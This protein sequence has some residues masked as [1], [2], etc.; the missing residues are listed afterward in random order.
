MIRPPLRD[1]LAICAALLLLLPGTA[2]LSAQGPGLRATPIQ[3]GA[4][5]AL[6]PTAETMDTRL[7]FA[8]M[9]YNYQKYEGAM[10]KYSEYLRSSPDG[11]ESAAAWFR[12]GDCHRRLNAPDDAIRCLS[13]YLK[14]APEGEFAAAAPFPSPASISMRTAMPIPCPT[15]PWPRSV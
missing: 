2:R 15:G 10:E 8:N 6:A 1:P 13:N 3:P 5:P 12:L 11:P 7:R 14:L 9:L 4:G